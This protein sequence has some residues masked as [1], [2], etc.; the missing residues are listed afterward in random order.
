MKLVSH[1]EIDL[2]AESSETFNS[3]AISVPSPPAGSPVITAH[4]ST[5]PFPSEQTGLPMST[6]ITA[7]PVGSYKFSIQ[8]KFI[9][10]LQLILGCALQNVTH[11]CAAIYHRYQ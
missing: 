10:C 11:V 6:V 2:L 3:T 5:D 1:K 7:S 9:H 8:N 4:T